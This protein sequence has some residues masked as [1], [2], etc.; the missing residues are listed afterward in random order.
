MR[1]K[2][3]NKRKTQLIQ[4]TKNTFSNWQL[5]IICEQRFLCLFIYLDISA[6]FVVF[7]TYQ[8]SFHS[9]HSYS[10]PIHSGKMP[11]TKTRLP[12][13]SDESL[14]YLQENTHSR[15]TK[16]KTTTRWKNLRFNMWSIPINM[17]AHDRKDRAR[18]W[19]KWKEKTLLL[20]VTAK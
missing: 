13:F 8:S 2:Y 4:Q 1:N 11:T 17:D 6:D 15:N 3:M 14:H 19:K 10:D 16:K 18:K 5:A 7:S 9:D 20:W 12:L